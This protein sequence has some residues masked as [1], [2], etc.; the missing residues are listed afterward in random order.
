MKLNAPNYYV[1]PGI[2]QMAIVMSDE[3]RANTILQVVKEEFSSKFNVDIEKIYERRRC[4]PFMTPR[5]VYYYFC[6][7]KIPGMSYKKMAEPFGHD[8]TTVMN[9]IQTIQNY[10]DVKDPYCYDLIVTIEKRLI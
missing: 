9:G 2:T 4:E 7:K 8:H 5:Q 10:I 1:F 3:H 6:R